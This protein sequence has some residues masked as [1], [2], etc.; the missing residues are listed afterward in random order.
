MNYK[1]LLIAI[2]VLLFSCKNKKNEIV[3]KTQLY[4]HFSEAT[5]TK[6]KYNKIF[7]SLNDSIRNW[8]INKL[9]NYNE[10]TTEVEYF[11]DSLLCFNRM[12]NKFVSARMCRDVESTRTNNMDGV[13]F[14]Y[15]VK[16]KEQWYFFSGATVYL[17][18]ENYER[19]TQIPLSFEKLHE[20]A[21]KEVFSGYLI[22]DTKGNWI[23]NDKFFDY[24]F[25]GAGWGCG[26]MKVDKNGM[27]QW[28]DTCSDETFNKMIFRGNLIK[29]Y[30]HV[31]PPGAQTFINIPLA[32]YNK[33]K[34]MGAIDVDNEWVSTKIKFPYHE[35]IDVN[36]V[37]DSLYN[38]ISK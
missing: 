16:I 25:K 33:Y 19:N 10:D 17:P 2:L 9:K 5:V 38:Q 13:V 31:R 23:I 7:F 37:A 30:G 26:Y 22:K 34:A 36:R 21:M 24:H 28:I 11:F 1:L 18:R 15:G 8:R 14:Y 29:W 20:I 32:T 27:G 12:G 3:E 4:K 6:E 35:I